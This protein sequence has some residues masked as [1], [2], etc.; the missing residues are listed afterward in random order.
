[1]EQQAGWWQG[2]GNW[3]MT[4]SVLLYRWSLFPLRSVGKS[5]H[6]SECIQRV[7]DWRDFSR[8]I[9]EL[10]VITQCLE[11]PRQ[12]RPSSSNLA[13]NRILW[14]VR[15][16]ILSR[17]WGTREPFFQNDR[18]DSKSSWLIFLFSFFV[19]SSVR[20]AIQETNVERRWL[21][22]RISFLLVTFLSFLL[23][24]KRAVYS[25]VTR[26]V[27]RSIICFEWF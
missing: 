19:I 2:A 6:S 25:H 3:S 12:F 22:R 5:E 26:R 23:S 18:C 17:S 16:S 20:I 14:I 24:T 10:A 8:A 1:M 9:I 21:P 7:R 4:C 27:K 15:A 11:F 13:L